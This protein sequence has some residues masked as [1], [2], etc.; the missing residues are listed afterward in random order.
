[1]S[2]DQEN[3]PSSQQS[4]EARRKVD[5]FLAA[6]EQAMA[7]SDVS[8]RERQNVIEDLRGQIGEMLAELP[9]QPPTPVDV[10]A[11]LGQLDP[12]ASYG[13]EGE[14]AAEGE[15]AAPEGE[16]VG[17]AGSAGDDES[18]PQKH[19]QQHRRH[20]G[21]G[22]WHRRGRG[23]WWGRWRHRGEIAAAIKHAVMRHGPFAFPPFER[24]TDRA[25]EVIVLAKSEARKLNHQYIG[26][27]H[28]LL[29]L[30]REGTGV[31]AVVLNKLGLGAGRV[32]DEILQFVERGPEPVTAER[33]PLTPRAMAVIQLARESARELGH[34][35]VGTE[36]LLLGEL[37]EGMGVGA[38]VLQKV[39]LTGEQI[40]AEVMAAI[41]RGATAETSQARASSSSSSSP[42]T[43]WPPGTG[44][45]VDVDGQTWTFIAT[46]ADT[47]GAFSMFDLTVPAGHAAPTIVHQRE[48]KAYFI[49]AGRLRF[50]LGQRTINAEAGAFVR[51]PRG[52][53]HALKNE[54]TEAARA[55]VTVTPAGLERFLVRMSESNDEQRAA[56]LK[57][58]GIEVL[59]VGA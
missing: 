26:T 45:V 23:G 9:T 58:F 51:V 52:T 12:P 59:G 19:E 13:G 53:E 47:G 2:D 25:R 55:V 41:G 31:A 10:E 50:E 22:G 27:E 42:F 46:G 14:G 30:A 56:V 5:A 39:G 24:F 48:D 40:R 29:G 38:K 3:S 33:L 32:R 18:R 28:L 8:A 6:V 15:A 35:F 4:E 43:Y 7:K 1:M 16:A 54:S 36:H 21:E 49:T 37:A 17:A 57:Q 11:V 44:K 20:C 34:D